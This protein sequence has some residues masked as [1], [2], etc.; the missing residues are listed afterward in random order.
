[1]SEQ[2]SMGE[3][4]N[5][6]T[7]AELAKEVQE[8]ENE[9]KWLRDKLEQL[10]EKIKEVERPSEAKGEDGNEKEIPEQEEED[11]S[12]DQ[13][14]IFNVLKSIGGRVIAGHARLLVF[15]GKMN[16]GVM[17]WLEALENYFDCEEI[18]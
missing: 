2:E 9:N 16:V 8:Q 14:A 4:H 18:T 13:K 1:M 3:T 12:E 6:V 11:I 7:N 5:K 17:H 15:S 10:E